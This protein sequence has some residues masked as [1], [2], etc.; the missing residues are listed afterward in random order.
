MPDTTIVITIILVIITI[1]TITEFFL[2]AAY[3]VYKTGATTGIADIGRAVAAII[4]AIT[5]RP[6][7]P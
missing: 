5:N 4:A 6:P 1:V 2:L 7:P 3:I